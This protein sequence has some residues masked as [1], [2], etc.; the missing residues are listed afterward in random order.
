MLNKSIFTLLMIMGIF[1]WFSSGQAPKEEAFWKWFNNNESRLYDFEKDQDRIFQE[2]SA[3]LTKINENLVF[4]FGPKENGVRDFVISADGIKKAFPFV[5]SLADKAP[6]LSRWKIIK[7]RPRRPP[8]PEIRYDGVSRKLDQIKF[9]LEPDGGKAGMTIFIDGYESSQHQKFLG[10][11]FL[12][13]D[14]CLGEY[15]VETKVGFIKVEAM[16]KA[17]QVEKTPLSKLPD[18]FDRFFAAKN[19]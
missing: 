1:S 15:D 13:L 12:Y 7:F 14:N 19:P 18:I 16:T 9:T 8:F 5:V 3:E 10:I 17:T 11:A 4:E 6:P 2:L